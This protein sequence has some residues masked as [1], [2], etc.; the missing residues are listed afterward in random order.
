MED[1]DGQETSR[2]VKKEIQRDMHKG[3]GLACQAQE[4][5]VVENPPL[6]EER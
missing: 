3:E 1:G 2:H 5:K 6:A 4:S